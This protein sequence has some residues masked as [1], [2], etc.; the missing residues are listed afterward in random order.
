MRDEKSLGTIGLQQ[1]FLTLLEL[2]NPTSF[3]RAFTEPYYNV[4]YD[5]SVC[6]DLRGR[7]STKPL[8]FD[9]TQV[10]NHWSTKIKATRAT[11]LLH[12]NTIDQ[13]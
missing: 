1:W 3:I 8:G 13:I 6:L 10:K 9:R 11:K 12:K 5:E 7:G 4:K 2:P